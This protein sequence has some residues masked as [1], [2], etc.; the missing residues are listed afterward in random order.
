MS[1]ITFFNSAASSNVLGHLSS[2]NNQLNK[3]FERLSTGYKVNHASDGS[4]DMMIS[5]NLQSQV[6]G[7]DVAARNIQDGLSML[8]SADS[9]MQQINEHLQNIRTIA[10]A[11]SNGTTNTAQFTAYQNQVTQEV[12][13]INDIANNTKYNGQNILDG[14]ISG[15]G[16]AFNIQIGPNSGDTV[17]IKTAFSDA[18]VGASGLGTISTTLATA[19]NATTIL[20]QVDTALDALSGKL[21]TVGTFE[22]SMQNQMDYLNIAKANTQSS[23][24]SIR[25]TDVAA[26]SANLAHLQ[27]LQQGAVYALSQMQNQSAIAMKFLQ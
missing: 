2:L 11:A 9:A 18:T 5:Q 23:L 24:S 10:V 14:T 27:I 13:A 20:G 12:N 3:S 21:S 1:G 26:E 15:G 25:D 22:S 16:T 4:A 7:Y 8:Q 6:N 17:D 19:A